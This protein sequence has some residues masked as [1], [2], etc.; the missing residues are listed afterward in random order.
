MYIHVHVYAWWGAKAQNSCKVCTFLL[1]ALHT[2]FFMYNVCTYMYSTCQLQGIRLVT[3]FC[4]KRQPH[5]YTEANTCLYI[6]VVKWVY[7]RRQTRLHEKTNVFAL[8]LVSDG[9]C[10][11]MYVYTYIHVH[12]QVYTYAH[13]HVFSVLSTALL[14][15]SSTASA[16]D[17]SLL[18]GQQLL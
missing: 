8:Y 1:L 6:H 14:W 7:T 4:T 13:V 16:G 2:W 18:P 5:L 9:Y 10:T 12:V 15:N 3:R 11:Y 17:S